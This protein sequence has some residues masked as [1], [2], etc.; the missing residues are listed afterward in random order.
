MVSASFLGSQQEVVEFSRTHA[1]VFV[2]GRW[3]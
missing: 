3:D 1:L 2:L